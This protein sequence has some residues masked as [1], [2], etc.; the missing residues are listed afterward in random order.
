MTTIDLSQYPFRPAPYSPPQ[1]VS[2]TRAD[3]SILLRSALAMELPT[4][5]TVTE[6]LPHWA[7]ERADTPMFLQRTPEG[8]W[9]QV[10]YA[11]A[12]AEVQRLAAQ[13]LTLS[14]SEDRPLAMLSG[15]SI[16]YALM[17]YAADYAGVTVATVSPAYSMMSKDFGRLKGVLDLVTPGAFFVQA[18]SW[19]APVLKKLAEWEFVES[20]I[21][22]VQSSNPNHRLYSQLAGLALDPT[23]QA[24]LDQAHAAIKSTDVARIYFTSGSTGAPK[25]VPMTHANF[26][27]TERMSIQQYTG[28][29]S[30]P[31][32]YLDWLPWHHAFG[33][34]ANLHRALAHGNSIYIDEG[35]PLPGLFAATIKNLRDIKVDGFANVPAGFAMLAAELERD[36]ALAAHFFKGIDALG[37]G[38]AALSRDTWERIETVAVRAVGEKIAFLSG[39]GA[40]ETTA[41][42]TLFNW[43]SDDVGNIGTPIPGAEIKLVP[44]GES[45][46]ENARYECRTRGPHVFSGYWKRPDLTKAAFDEEGFYK[47]GDAVSFVDPSTPAAGLRFVGRVVEDFKLASGT[48]VRVGSVRLAALDLF[49]PLVRDAVVCG[50]D[51]DEVGVLAWPNEAACRALDPSLKEI[52]LADLLVHPLVTGVLQQRIAAQG[53]D[54]GSMAIKRIAMLV[55]PPSIDA[56]EIADKGYVNQAAT[57]ARRAA[58]VE[59]LYR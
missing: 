7:R 24:A 6:Y 15:N 59:A 29:L 30:F 50:H 9:R 2:E 4:R 5:K 54:Q 57:L 42:G 38:G 41:A 47:L 10:N 23:A 18:A 26:M 28:D 8:V 37:Y 46:R 44:A 56:G 32:V 21:I 12:W 25:G 31:R 53:P 48:W 19:Y 20:Q 22:A 39:Y 34:V 45:G 36:P 1:V 51:R 58:L 17:L 27:A 43:A 13:L 35:K 49:T 16:E 11:Q 14:L 40:T 33:G 3:G 52:A 55:E